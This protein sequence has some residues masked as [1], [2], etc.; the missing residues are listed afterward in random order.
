MLLGIFENIIGFN[1]QLSSH[2]VEK[3]TIMKW[4]LARV[5][6]KTHDEN[7]GYAAELLVILLQNNKDN[8]A[9]F[10]ATDGIEILLTVASVSPSY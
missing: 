9:K 3:T 7:R 1:P 8:R 6:G 4:L 5:Q 2:L 10:A